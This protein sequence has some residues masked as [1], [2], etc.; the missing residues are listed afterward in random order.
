MFTEFNQVMNWETTVIEIT[1][2][3]VIE[4]LISKL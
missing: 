3:T 4:F 2:I 1:V